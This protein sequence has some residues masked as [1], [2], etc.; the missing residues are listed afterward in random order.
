MVRS[1]CFPHQ[2][3]RRFIP[4][5]RFD[6][7]AINFGHL[8]VGND[9]QVKWRLWSPCPRLPWTPCFWRYL[10][11]KKTYL[12]HQTS[13]GKTGRLGMVATYYSSWEMILQIGTDHPWRQIFWWKKRHD[14]TVFSEETAFGCSFFTAQLSLELFFLDFLLTLVLGKDKNIFP[15]W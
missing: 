9:S 1:V 3:P 13:G 11:P 8:E 10:D 14:D 6:Y 15:K 5:W 4:T 7:L 2:P 12:K